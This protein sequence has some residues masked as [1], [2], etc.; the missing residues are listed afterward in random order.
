MHASAGTDPRQQGSDKRVLWACMRASARLVWPVSEYP[1]APTRRAGGRR[2]CAGERERPETK[3]S[4]DPTGQG[5]DTD[6]QSRAL[7]PI[8]RSARL[9]PEPAPK[10]VSRSVGENL[11]GTASARPAS[12]AARPPAK[13]LRRLSRCGARLGRR[14]EAHGVTEAPPCVGVGQPAGRVLPLLGGSLGRGVVSP[15]LGCVRGASHCV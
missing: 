15:R 14:R 2:A 8:K 9:G 11:N 5:G 1:A 12:G 13:N 10:P 4:P 6:R 7:Q 3:R